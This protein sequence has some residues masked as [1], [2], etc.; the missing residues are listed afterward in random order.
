MRCDNMAN[1]FN[2]IKE[3]GYDYVDNSYKIKKEVINLVSKL[4]SRWSYLLQQPIDKLAST[5]FDFIRMAYKY[6]VNDY[7]DYLMKSW[8]LKNSKATL[9][10]LEVRVLDLYDV[11]STNPS[12]VFSRKNGK[13]Y[14][15]AT[16]I[17]MLD[18]KF[19]ELGVAFTKQYK[20]IDGLLSSLK[21]KKMEFKD[22]NIDE[23]KIIMNMASKY[24]QNFFE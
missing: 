20:L 11:L 18:K 7:E 2:K 16:S 5:Q 3:T 6:R 15:Y 1:K 10:A 17:R 24:F 23:D 22:T 12:K 19:E 14:N 9:Q 13:N 21:K 4:S 8:Y